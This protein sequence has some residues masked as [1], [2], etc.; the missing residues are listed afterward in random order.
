MYYMYMYI[1]TIQLM[2]F[3]SLKKILNISF[4][5]KYKNLFFNLWCL[6][7]VLKLDI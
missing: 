7:N 1:M 3:M 6:L 2:L 4:N 5:I